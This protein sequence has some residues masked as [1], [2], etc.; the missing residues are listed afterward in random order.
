[1]GMNIQLSSLK[2][3]KRFSQ[4]DLL[5]DRCPLRRPIPFRIPMSSELRHTP[6]TP[7]L[8]RKTMMRMTSS[9]R[10]IHTKTPHLSITATRRADSYELITSGSQP[11]RA[12][13]QSPGDCIES[14]REPQS[15]PSSHKCSGRIRPWVSIAPRSNRRVE[16]PSPPFRQTG[17][18]FG[19]CVSHAC[20]RLRRWRVQRRSWRAVARSPT[21]DRSGSPAPVTFSNSQPFQSRPTPPPAAF[22]LPF[23]RPQTR[24]PD[25]A[26]ASPD[27]PSGPRCIAAGNRLLWEE[28]RRGPPWTGHIG[29][30]LL[31]AAVESNKLFPPLPPQPARLLLASFGPGSRCVQAWAG[32]SDQSSR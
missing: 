18:S 16:R 26:L 20:S 9:K 25:A 30:D 24:F 12:D 22:P 31:V 27:P 2:M 8:F 14:M 10:K 3:I 17:A 6:S 28:A 15:R 29:Y 23:R 7:T 32:R 1:V 13:L 11:S 21:S 5:S 4:P 19:V